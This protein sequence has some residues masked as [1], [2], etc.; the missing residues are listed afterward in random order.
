LSLIDVPIEFVV[1][2]IEPIIHNFLH[3]LS[4]GGLT[5]VDSLISKTY[6]NDL[7]YHE[8]QNDMAFLNKL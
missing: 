1:D 6:N 2:M 5:N 7:S 3:K 4:L 8:L